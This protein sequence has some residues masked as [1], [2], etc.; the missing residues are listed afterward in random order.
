M[1]GG[2]YVRLKYYRVVRDGQSFSKKQVADRDAEA[3]QGWSAGK[4]FFKEP[5]DRRFLTDYR[6]ESAPCQGCSGSEVAIRFGSD[7]HD[8]QHGNGTM[9]IDMP[10]G[11]VQALTYTPNVLPPHATSGTVTETG[12][13]AAPDVWYVTRIEQKYDGRLFLLSGAVTV[14]STF[15]HFQRFATVAQGEAAL[16]EGTL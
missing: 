8:A 2:A 15:D 1:N 14:I 7:V 16:D 12:S 9:R 6:F 11:R 4:I 5:Y 10:S 3:N 13:Q